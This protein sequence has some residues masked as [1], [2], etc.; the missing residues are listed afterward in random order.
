MRKIKCYKFPGAERREIKKIGDKAVTG[1]KRE[2]GAE[3][4]PFLP[5]LLGRKKKNPAR[6]SART[7]ERMYA[8]FLLDEDEFQQEDDS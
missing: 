4:L 1:S 8:V 3:G 7:G 2:N 6:A 5:P